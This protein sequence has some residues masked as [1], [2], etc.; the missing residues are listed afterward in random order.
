MANNSSP[1]SSPISLPQGGGAMNGIGEKFSPDLFTGTGNFSIPIS[2]P[3]GRNGFQPELSLAYSTGN[4]NGPFGLGWALSIPGISRKTSQG[5]P[6]YDDTKDVFIL[7][8]AEDLVEVPGAPVGAKRYRPRTEGLF[9]LIDH[10]NQNGINYWQVKS[11]DGFTSFY[12]TPKPENVPQDWSDSS[13]IADPNKK[14]KIFS[15]SLTETRDTFGNS[16]KY[17][18]DRE[19]SE[20]GCQIYLKEIQYLNFKGDSGE[21]KYLVAVR[22]SYSDRPDIFSSYR[23]GFEVS[24]R[25]RCPKI[26]I[27]NH[28]KEDGE[29]RPPQWLDGGQLIRTYKFAYQKDAMN[30][31]SLLTQVN[32][33][34]HDNEVTEPMPPLEFSYTR[35]NPENRKFFPLTGQLP[36]QSLNNANLTLVDLS[37]NGL[38]DFLEMNGLITRYWRNLGEGRFDLPKDM[39]DAPAG[40]QLSDENVQLVDANGDGR[41]DLMV[42]NGTQGGYYPARFD[43]K[44][45][46]KSFQPFKQQPSFKLKDPEVQLVDLNGDG[47][48]DVIRS[49]QRLECFFLDA[50]EG[51]NQVRWVERKGLA[52]FPNISFSD[53]RVRWADMSGDGMQDIVLVHDGKIEYWPNLGHG[54]WAAKKAM[55]KSPRLPFGF[56][57]RRVILGDVDGDGLADLILVEDTK[58]TLWIN[59]NGNSWS[60][61]IVIKGTPP[62]SDS[63]NLRLVDLLGNGVAGLLWSSNAN[64]LERSRY[65]FLDFTGGVKPY[66]LCE[67][68]NH[69]GALTR[70][71]YR[72]ST[73]YFL[74][75][76]KRPIT[77]WLTNLPFPVQVVARVEVIDEISKGK[78]TTEYSY[79]HGYWDGAERE[80][81]GFGRV[82]QRDSETFQHYHAENL[83]PGI[84][85]EA[86]QTEHFSPPLETRSWFH[87]GP[88]GGEFG[89]WKETDFSHE[90]WQVD[91]NMLERSTPMK[92]FLINL[93]RRSKRDALRTLRGRL[94]RT[95]LY[96][97]DDTPMQ[98]RP[99]TV[100]EFLHSVTGIPI[101]EPWQPNAAAWQQKVFFPHSRAQRTTQWERGDDPMTQLAFTEDYDDFGQPLT[102]IAIACPQGWRSLQDAVLNEGESP[103]ECTKFLA[104]R[105]TVQ[106]A[107]PPDGI[108]IQN[109]PCRSVTYELP[110][111]VSNPVRSSYQIEDMKIQALTEAAIIAE[112]IQYYDGQAFEGLPEGQCGEFGVISRTNILVLTNSILE[113]VWGKG[114]VP[115]WLQSANPNWP[116]NYPAGFRER[117]AAM[118]G[119]MLSGDKCYASQ[120]NRYD[121]QSGIEPAYGLL[122]STKDPLG[123]E[124]NIQYDDFDFLPVQVENAVGLTTTAQYNYRTFQPQWFQDENGNRQHFTFSP[125]GLPKSIAIMGKKGEFVGDENQ[126]G[127]EPSTCFDYDFLAFCNSPPAERRPVWVKTTKREF[128][129]TDPDI[130]AENR[131][132]TIKTVEYSDG[133]GRLVQTRTQAEDTIWTME[134]TIADETFGNNV[135]PVE[136]D[137]TTAPGQKKQKNQP[138]IGIRNTDLE[139]PNVVVSG[140]QVYD[141]KGKVVEK[142][143]PFFAKGWQF[144]PPTDDQKGQKA[145]M[146]YDP[147]GQVI[148]TLNPDGSEQ[149]VIYGVPDF[150]DQPERFQ[151]KPWEAYT[152]DANDNAGRTHGA[153]ASAYQN[154][155]NTPSS[156]LIDALGRT[157]VAVSRTT[158]NETFITRSQYDI[159]GNLIAVKDPLG[160]L[161]FTYC[162]DLS[163]DKEKGSRPLRIYSIDAG[164]RQMAIDARGM[165]MER[166]D[167]KGATSWQAYDALGRPTH[168][169]AKDKPE[170]APTLRQWLCYGDEPTLFAAEGAMGLN[171][172]GKLCHHYDEAGKLALTAYDFKGNLLQKSR[173]VIKD[174]AIL[175]VMGGADMQHFVV[176]WTITEGG[177]M[178]NLETTW[179][180]DRSYETDMRYDALNRAVKMTYPEDVEGKR[181]WVQPAYNRAG[182]LEQLSL[183]V[184]NGTGGRSEQK[185]VRQIAYNA[186]GQRTLIAYGN[187]ILTRYAYQPDTFR[188]S[189]LLNEKYTWT[190]ER[191][192][193]P[194]NGTLQD[195]AYTYD[196]AGN[197]LSI[198]HR[199]PQSGIG[200]SDS[201]V[202]KFTYDPLYRVLTATGREQNSS[203][204]SDPAQPW[205][206]DMQSFSQDS[207]KTRGYQQEF[208]YDKAGN[209][210]QLRHLSQINGGTRMDVTYVKN[211]TPRQEN[212]RLEV[213]TQGNN[214]F[215]YLYDDNGNMTRETNSR[216]YHWNHADQLHAFRQQPGDDAQ[217]TLEARYLY[218]AGGMRVKKLVHTNGAT[219][220]TVYL[221]QVFEYYHDDNVENNTLHLMDDQN[222]VALIR[223]GEAL[224]GDESPTV[225]YQLGDHLGNTNVSLNE[226]GT[227]VSKEEYY[228]YGATSFG[229]YGKKRYRYSGK[230]RDEESGLEYYGARYYLSWSMKWINYDPPYLLT[231]NRLQ[232]SNDNFHE[233]N[234]LFNSY[235]NN[236]ILYYDQYGMDWKNAIYKLWQASEV[237]RALFAPQTGE[238]HELSSSVAKRPVPQEQASTSASKPNPSGSG[239]KPS[240]PE[241]NPIDSVPNPPR[242]LPKAPEKINPKNALESAE[243]HPTQ[244]PYNFWRSARGS[245]SI[246]S[247]L[248]AGF[249]AFM[250]MDFI[251]EVNE[252]IDKDKQGIG[253][254]NE[255]AKATVKATSRTLAM[256]T[257]ATYLGKEGATMFGPW[258][259]LLGGIA[260]GLAG[261][262]YPE[263]IEGI[264]GNDETNDN[265]SPNKMNEHFYKGGISP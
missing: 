165:E 53:P 144:E 90:F 86:V 49:G 15:W 94:L 206:E 229:G 223:V 101:N 119:F 135:L 51:W 14:D 20:Q 199:E 148:R 172:M 264:F 55:Q 168:S 65:F 238:V 202:R 67:M 132:E 112:T 23:S 54:N 150:L 200:G 167:S 18:Y 38:P 64:G 4:G 19:T 241:P 171:L 185:F 188:L 190:D 91:P 263:T 71:E 27:F 69:M 247:L 163:F 138:I 80:F 224:H 152:Y 203:L 126:E 16:V 173:R 260:G 120:G 24:T 175:A 130:A 249:A 93:P 105:S 137:E 196:L 26:E 158:E 181:R 36:A 191:T 21:T 235:N 57:P 22:F 187:D 25:K 214:T 41:T 124:T 95:E 164:L 75:D 3:S 8:G 9:A 255:T 159:R 129:I 68:N 61:P 226:N 84:S 70:V 149:R 194:N 33:T 254:G 232:H 169:W 136:Q 29:G 239:P 34:G 56:D 108:Y 215:P 87:Q 58:V 151:P 63:D 228:P 113:Q 142:Y 97:L 11:K 155:W 83:L 10:F 234:N 221:D 125:L 193:Q 50:K 216:R 140:W 48:T 192:I 42:L 62:M 44:W 205:L 76:Q 209:L 43:A 35:F 225:Q 174:E 179:L 107:R 100:I 207:K 1:N 12:G 37:G 2:L 118:G 110:H 246:G 259:G 60:D 258:G 88:I 74:E 114:Q 40:V 79:H 261:S 183:F 244:R 178:E 182:A 184:P 102:Q 39:K 89:E 115:A 106:Y 98:N 116:E 218:D 217:P 104:T 117:S 123:F 111:P 109:R 47:I 201:L 245:I 233:S 189:R 81:R 78:L 262:F 212:N 73:K 139:N 166:R 72:S 242:K 195:F 251:S 52:Q 85:F 220:T 147:R 122:L 240:S 96:A 13:I 222:R 243:I 204:V 92:S 154:H 82:D 170:Q 256:I 250:A 141:N 5:I 160:R 17:V 156:I 30:G 6:V 77:R 253:A 45:D 176:D 99:Y 213:V 28:A 211:L 32:V 146:Y 162:Y 180:E 103:G 208:A 121:F 219:R 231:P 230:E 257:G 128:H 134:G 177:T 161:A 145:K 31:T 197:I 227:W 59:Q 237:L 210:I 66:L 198:S 131:N 157:L 127:I 153:A 248:I 186:K 265:L 143:E 46:R 236:P 252:G 133:F 7:S